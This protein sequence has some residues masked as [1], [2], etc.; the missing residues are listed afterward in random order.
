MGGT[1]KFF[2][3]TIFSIFLKCS[4]CPPHQGGI[5]ILRNCIFD[6]LLPPV[7]G[8]HISATPLPLEGHYVICESPKM[9]FL[10]SSLV[11]FS[12]LSQSRVEIGI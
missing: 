5:H 2:C 8:C 4:Q 10:T 3:P 11:L 12:N 7:M 1:K 9:K 6:S